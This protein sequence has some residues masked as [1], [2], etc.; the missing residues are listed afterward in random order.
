MESSGRNRCWESI[1]SSW[2]SVETAVQHRGSPRDSRRLVDIIEW[3]YPI[4][5]GTKTCDSDLPD[6]LDCYLVELDWGEMSCNQELGNSLSL[7]VKKT[8]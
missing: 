5:N 4:T 6:G 7:A 2:D 3:P 8:A 1:G